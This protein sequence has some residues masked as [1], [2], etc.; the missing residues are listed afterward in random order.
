MQGIDGHVAKVSSPGYGQVSAANLL[1]RAAK[2]TSR[3][4]ANPTIP[5]LNGEFDFALVPGN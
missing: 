5:I 1:G 4:V 3:K 2:F